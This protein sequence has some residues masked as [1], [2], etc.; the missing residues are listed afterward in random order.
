MRSLPWPTLPWC[1]RPSALT[2]MLFEFN[3]LNWTCCFLILHQMSSHALFSRNH[4]CRE[5]RSVSIAR[6]WATKSGL[7]GTSVAETS[8]ESLPSK[9]LLQKTLLSKH[10]LLKT[11]WPLKIKRSYAALMLSQCHNL[12]MKFLWE[13]KS[14]IKMIYFPVMFPWYP[15]TTILPALCW[16]NKTGT[17]ISWLVFRFHGSLHSIRFALRNVSES[18][19]NWC[20]FHGSMI[21]FVCCHTASANMLRIAPYGCLLYHR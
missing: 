8:F 18:C 5:K 17:C 14:A 3:V 7:V 1:L 20:H 15:I 13:R 12:W 16:W 19:F 21:Y 11:L 4:P 9:A 6:S 2:L 10:F